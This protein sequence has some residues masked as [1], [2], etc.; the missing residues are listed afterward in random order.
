MSAETSNLSDILLKVLGT[1]NHW[2]G[3]NEP[4][5]QTTVLVCAGPKYTVTNAHHKGHGS[6]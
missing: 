4:P 6:F 3:D 5:N 1:A 2:V